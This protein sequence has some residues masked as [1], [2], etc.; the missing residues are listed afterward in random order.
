[1]TSE[2]LDRIER[3]P[4]LARAFG[5]PE[6]QNAIQALTRN[7]KAAFEKYTKERPDLVLALREF[8]GLLGDQM[9]TMGS[10]T[11]NNASNTTTSSGKNV[12]IPDD[13]PGHE[14]ELIRR[15]QSDP[16]VQVSLSCHMLP[17]SNIK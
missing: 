12:E 15:V 17:C 1:M 11:E 16:E 8:S 9:D 14:K 10:A 5:D 2:F 7:P 13:L 3:N 4:V 6:F